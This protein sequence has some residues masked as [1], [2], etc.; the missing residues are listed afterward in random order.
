MAVKPPA[1]NT[2]SRKSRYHRPSPGPRRQEGSGRHYP[3]PPSPVPRLPVAWQKRW[4]VPR[5]RT[6]WA[7]SLRKGG[8]K[9]TG[10]PLLDPEA[11]RGL[12]GEEAEPGPRQDR[13]ADPR[14][15]KGTDE[16]AR[17]RT[18]EREAA[19][20]GVV[21]IP[22]HTR[23][24]KQSIREERAPGGPETCPWSAPHRREGQ[25]GASWRPRQITGPSQ[26]YKVLIYSVIFQ[27]YTI[28]SRKIKTK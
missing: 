6:C 26:G 10:K 5:A 13:E 21:R 27:M 8:S 25:A 20:A 24:R 19:E 23:D 18:E 11:G 9:V 15:A 16:A 2:D 17:Q 3:P 7:W 4:K 22:L 1:G 12:R 28:Q 14:G